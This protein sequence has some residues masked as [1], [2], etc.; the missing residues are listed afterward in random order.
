LLNQNN[1]GK[2]LIAFD[3]GLIQEVRIGKNRVYNLKRDFGSSKHERNVIVSVTKNWNLK[4]YIL[5]CQKKNL[6]SKK[7]LFRK[8]DTEISLGA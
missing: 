7:I 5:I 3:V 6:Y 2:K 4:I 8:I 1:I